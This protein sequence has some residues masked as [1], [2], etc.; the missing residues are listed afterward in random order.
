ML[1]L[2]IIAWLITYL[3]RKSGSPTDNTKCASCLK[4]LYHIKFNFIPQFMNPHDESA[5]CFV[6]LRPYMD[7]D[8]VTQLTCQPNHVMHSDCFEMWTAARKRTCPKCEVVL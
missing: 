5:M 1:I 3:A 4:L 6:C 8:Q 7:E 2:A